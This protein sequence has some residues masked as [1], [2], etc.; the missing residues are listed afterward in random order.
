MLVRQDEVMIKDDGMIWL[1]DACMMFSVAG[2][3]DAVDS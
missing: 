3:F 1:A 2:D